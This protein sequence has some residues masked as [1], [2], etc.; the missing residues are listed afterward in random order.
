M[1][2]EYLS[3]V[4]QYLR[5]TFS[6]HDELLIQTISDGMDEIKG[7][8]YQGLVFNFTPVEPYDGRI[9]ALLRDYV[10]YSWNGSSQYFAEDYRRTI[11]RL[12]LEI[13]ASKVVTA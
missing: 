7:M 8:V 1:P 3:S 11:T 4:K 9:N 5:V 13:G 12:S 6:D 10:R 2:E